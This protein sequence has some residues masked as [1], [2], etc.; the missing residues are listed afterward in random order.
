MSNFNVN[1]LDEND[2]KNLLKK[3][4]GTTQARFE[5]RKKPLNEK[6]VNVDQKEIDR[7]KWA[8]GRKEK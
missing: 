7:I 6:P 1:P 3:F 8:V 5:N 2:F 4:D